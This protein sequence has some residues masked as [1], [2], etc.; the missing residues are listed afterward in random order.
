VL[1]DDL[2]QNFVD[3]A[4]HVRRISTNVEVGLLLEEVVNLGGA[5]AQ[6]VL[7]VDFLGAGAGEGGDDFEGVAEGGFVFLENKM[8]VCILGGV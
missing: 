6:A 2:P 3:L 5:F 4:R 8:L 7:D 1:G